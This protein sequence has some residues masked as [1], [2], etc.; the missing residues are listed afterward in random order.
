MVVVWGILYLFEPNLKPFLFQIM[1]KI[2]KDV[3]VYSGTRKT[4][5]KRTNIVSN[6]SCPLRGPFIFLPCLCA[7]LTI[8]NN[9]GLLERRNPDQSCECNFFGGGHSDT[10]E[11]SET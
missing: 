5:R 8:T 10:P 6:Y 3:A 9:D 11:K 4:R 7:D 1:D 2:L